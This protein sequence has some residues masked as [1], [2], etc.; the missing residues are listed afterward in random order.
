MT[1]NLTLVAALRALIDEP[2]GIAA[3]AQAQAALAE[4]RAAQPVVHDLLE[5]RAE[6]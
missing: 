4:A 6:V 3:Q 2:N 1:N 5:R